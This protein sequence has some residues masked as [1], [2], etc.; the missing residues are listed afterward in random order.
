MPLA[1]ELRLLIDVAGRERR[2]FVGRRML[3]V[4]VDA[5]GA[6]VHHAPRAGALRQL[7]DACRRAVALTAR[8]SAAGS[9]ASR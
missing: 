7:D 5:D 3:D 9:P 8:Y 2:V 4:A 6:A 1:F